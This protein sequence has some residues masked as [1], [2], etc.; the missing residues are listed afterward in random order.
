[1][2]AHVLIRRDGEIVQYVP[3]AERAWHAGVSAYRG[4]SGCND[5]SM[6]IELEGTDETPYDRLRSTRSSRALSAA[7]CSAP[8]PRSRREHIVGHSDV[9][10]G[11][12][13]DPGASFDWPRLRAALAA[14]LGEPERYCERSWRQSTSVPRSCRASTRAIT[15][16][17][18]ERRFR[19]C[20]RR[21]AHALL[22]RQRPH[23]PLGAPRDGA[24]Q[25][26]GRRRRAPAGQDEFLQRPAARR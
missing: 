16:S 2:S 4:R 23:A 15:N 22:L 3:F 20:G 25:V 12:K 8:I 14:R 21:G 26:A 1:M 6:G 7:R 10:P 19:Y 11:R 24:R 17:R 9:A 18:S 5:F 13:T